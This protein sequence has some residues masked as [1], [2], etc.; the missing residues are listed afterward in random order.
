MQSRYPFA[1]GPTTH[2]VTQINNKAA[3]SIRDVAPIT[4]AT[5][6]SHNLQPVALH[7][8]VRCVRLPHVEQQ[9]E[10]QQLFYNPI[11]KKA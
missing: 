1:V 3:W 4:T 11:L 8:D 6:A 10:Q 2:Q 5:I 7:S 9:Q